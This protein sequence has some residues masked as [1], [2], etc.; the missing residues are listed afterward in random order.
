M[1]RLLNKLLGKQKKRFN[2]KLSNE[3][4]SFVSTHLYGLK[5]LGWLYPSAP[6]EKDDKEQRIEK[7]LN[8]VNVFNKSINNIN[9]MITYF[10]DKNHNPKKKCKIYETLNTKL[11]TVDS[12]V[13]FAATATPI[14]LS[15]TGIRLII[16]P[17]I[18]VFAFALSSGDKVLH[19]M[20]SNIYKKKKQY[21]K[22]NN[23]LPFLMDYKRNLHT[24]K[25]LIKVNMNHYLIF[26]LNLLVKQ[27]MNL[28]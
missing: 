12:I 4:I 26:L 16:L 19:K 8:D 6:L 18:A 15:I 27:K 7:K 23:Q 9:E 25:S 24:M 21:E 22:T 3:E 2:S 20:I 28:F 11:E 1:K 10:K 13:N 17:I 14:T 5:D